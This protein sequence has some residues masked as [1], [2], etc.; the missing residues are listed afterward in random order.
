MAENAGLRV[1]GSEF[2]QQL[3]ERVL[4]GV[5]AGIGCFPVLVEASFIDDT[6]A[7]VVVVAGMHALNGLWQQGNDVTIAAHIVVV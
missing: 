5:G 3:V 7:A 2:L 1:V 4:L 6:E